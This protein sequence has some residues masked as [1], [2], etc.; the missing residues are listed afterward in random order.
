MWR[1]KATVV[2]VVIGGLR[3]VTLK[4]GECVKAIPG[5]TSKISIQK[6]TNL[7]TASILRRSLK[8]PGL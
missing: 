7:G 1:G 5:K 2:S 3:A 4:L 6:I 8:L